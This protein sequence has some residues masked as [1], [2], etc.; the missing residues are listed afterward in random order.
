MLCVWLNKPPKKQP[1]CFLFHPPSRSEDFRAKKRFLDL[2]SPTDVRCMY[3]LCFTFS[4]F[5]GVS[6]VMSEGFIVHWVE[7]Y[8]NCCQVLLLLWRRLM[9]KPQPVGIA[10][11]TCIQNIQHISF[12]ATDLRRK[13]SSN[14]KSCQK[15]ATVSSSLV[16]LNVCLLLKCAGL[17]HE[18]LLTCTALNLTMW[19]LQITTRLV[20]V[21]TISGF[22]SSWDESLFISAAVAHWSAT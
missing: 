10:R 1:H 19:R 14:C 4:L 22:S 11:I 8:L 16:P 3:Y 18:H 13:K 9:D 17:A 6:G 12:T 7:M 20:L 5:W 15:L 21:V 2:S